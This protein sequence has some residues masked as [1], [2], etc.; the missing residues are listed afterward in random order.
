MASDQPPAIS[1]EEALLECDCDEDAL[2][3][4]SEEEEEAEPES[5]AK[6]NTAGGKPGAKDK[7]PPAGKLKTKATGKRKGQTKAVETID[8]DDWKK[9]L[10]ERLSRSMA[11]STLI[12]PN[13]KTA[14]TTGEPTPD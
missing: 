13:A 3:K 10:S 4:F 2:L 8:P 1:F 9:C 11:S 14:T 5:G 12:K 7:T 6:E